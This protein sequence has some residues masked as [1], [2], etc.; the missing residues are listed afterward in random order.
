[1]IKEG[2]RKGGGMVTPEGSF[3]DKERMGGERR[4]RKEEALR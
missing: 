1:M 2:N 4:D 3:G